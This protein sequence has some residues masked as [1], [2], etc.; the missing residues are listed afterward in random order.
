[1]KYYKTYMDRQTVSDP[2]HE[3]L[4]A[5]EAPKSKRHW[6]TYTAL[7]ACL[8][9]IV[10]LGVWRWTA[11]PEA[12]SAADVLSEVGVLGDTDT[13]LPDIPYPYVKFPEVLA[14]I[15]LPD[16]AFTVKLL[17]HELD[18][19]LGTANL[20]LPG[21]WS[22]TA[23]LSARATY[24]GYGDLWQVDLQITEENGDNAYIQLAP[25]DIPPTCIGMPDGAVTDVNGVEVTSWG[26]HYDSDGDGTEEYHYH[27]VFMAGDIGVRAEFESGEYSAASTVF[28][29]Y[30]ANGN[31]D[32]SA[33]AKAD[34]V[35]A[36]R[37]VRFETYEEALQETDFLPYLPASIPEGFGEFGG[38][39]VY[40][41]GIDHHLVVWWRRDYDDLHL[42]ITL[43]EGGPSAAYDPVDISAPET[44]DRRLYSGGNWG[45]GLSDDLLDT[46]YF[47]TFRAEDMSLDV[48]EGRKLPRD[49]GGYS[50]QFHVLHPDGTAIEYS[51]S[52][53]TV[54]E[55]WAII[56]PTL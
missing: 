2:L 6:Q 53:L 44:W 17:P 30:A 41:E 20:Q 12:Q 19:L 37:S 48:I 45:D 16:G 49:R 32:L 40:Q 15:A 51:I 10:G 3:K 36:F 50:Y 31:L 8:A 7:A 46:L 13:A 27:S 28:I 23:K 26:A 11:P 34:D 39:L 4:L 14:D 38:K 52:G 55:V 29:N 35:P 21:V 5:M 33:I 42:Y 43:P 18:A 47:P 1:M 22:E 24:D 25:G 56:E 9:V 54:D